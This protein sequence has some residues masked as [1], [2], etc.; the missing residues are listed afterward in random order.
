MSVARRSLTI[1]AGAMLVALAGGPAFAATPLSAE[2]PSPAG[3]SSGAPHGVVPGRLI[4]RFASAAGATRARAVAS[5]VGGRLGRR[6]RLPGTR[7]LALPGG[8]DPH[9]AA[10]RAE[11]APGVLY[12]EP[13]QFIDFRAIPNDPLFGRQWGLQNTG[14]R[15]LATG[16]TP[17]ADVAGPAAWDLSVGSASVVVADVDTGADLQHPD[18]APNIWTNPGEVPDNHVDDDGNGLVDDLHGWDW[19]EADHIPDDSRGDVQGHGTETAS[20]IA[21]DGNN[22]IGIAGVNWNVSLMPL[23]TAT[24]SDTISAFIY[25]RDEGARAI[26]FSAGF[27]F[28]SR[29][30]Q[31]TIENIPTV[32]VVNAADNGGLNGRGDN[33]D[34]VRD[35]PCKFA[36]PNLVCVAASDQR[37]RLTPFSNFG[38]VSVD[39]AAPGRNVLAAY[40]ANAFSF[41]FGEF[42]DEPLGGRFTTGGRKDHWGRTRKLGES[43]TDSVRGRYRNNTNSFVTSRPIYLRDRRACEMA[44]FMVH[45]LQE[46]FDRLIVEATRDG[47]HWRHLGRF[48]GVGSGDYHFLRLPGNLNGAPGVRVRFRLVTDGRVRLDGVYLD[49]VQVTCITTG[50]AYAFADGTSFAA[51]H[52]AGAA[53]LVWARYPAGSVAEVKARLIGSVDQIPSMAGKLASGGRLDVARA[54]P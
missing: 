44:F 22:G 12:A 7:L 29:A 49:D 31:D 3:L 47:R 43:L 21:A 1:A 20:L 28:Y 18:L 40:P 14:Q 54:L 48:S 32:M 24:L 34:R 10:R 16:G 33:S 50:P 30:L 4:V 46:R 41:D 37:D 15:L 17:G 39:L 35:F 25:A 19:A 9:R 8:A 2:A 51:P 38:P 11:R 36:S 5:V 45:R 52:V 6:L 42:F 13:D 27:P 23:R 53:A 26:N